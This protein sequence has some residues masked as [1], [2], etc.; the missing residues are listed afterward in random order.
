MSRITR[1]W[2]PIEGRFVNSGIESIKY[3]GEDADRM[4][5]VKVEYQYTVN[6]N[7]YSSKKIFYGDYIGV[8]TPNY[9]RK[10][11]NKYA[12]KEKLTIYY[13]PDKPCKSVLE[14]K[15][16]PIIYRE[17][18]VGICFL[19]LSVAMIVKESFFVA[20]MR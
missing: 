10:A 5:K 7:T 8:N 20:F 9:A 3:I 19:S 17:L 11:L 14:T 6:G 4:Y 12:N 1:R 16:S 15:I 2:I 18:I 13:N